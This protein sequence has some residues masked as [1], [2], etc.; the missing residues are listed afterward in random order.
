VVQGI[1]REKAG[2]MMIDILWYGYLGLLAIAAIGTLI[3]VGY[4]TTGTKLDFVFSIITWLGLFGYVTSNQILTPLVWKFVFVFGLLW[5]VIF[6]FKKFLEDTKY[7]DKSLSVRLAIIG[8]TVL[9]S[10]GPL[11]YGLFHYAFK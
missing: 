9:I 5:D 11:Y 7:D 3:T 10:L 1:T 2:E 8:I 4:R 6:S